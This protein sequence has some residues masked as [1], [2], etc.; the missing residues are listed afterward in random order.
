[1]LEQ[2]LPDPDC[3]VAISELI[4][5]KKLDFLLRE[6]M[7]AT[8][9][10]RISELINPHCVQYLLANLDTYQMQLVLAQMDL[11]MN[12]LN[13]RIEGSSSDMDPKDIVDLSNEIARDYFRETVLVGKEAEIADKISQ[14]YFHA[15]LDE[16][17]KQYESSLK[18]NSPPISISEL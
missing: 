13:R 14:R 2:Y 17:L 6:R 7:G 12:Q 1:M 8:L 5:E 10:S 4:R 15:K 16:C 11:L 9:E 3:D 18:A